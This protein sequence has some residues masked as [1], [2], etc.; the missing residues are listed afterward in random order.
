MTVT[1]K[2]EGFSELEAALDEISKSAGKGVLRRSLKIAATPMVALAKA[3]VP[4]DKGTLRDSIAV[5]S[6]LDKR[7]AGQHRKMFRDD[8]ASVEMFVGPSYNLGKGGRHAHLVEFGTKPHANGGKFAGTM[9]PGTR[10]QPFM[11]P[12]WDKDQKAMLD[13]I[14]KELWVQL[15]KSI[16]R[17]ARKSARG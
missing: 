17:A 12:A 10:P 14:G 2:I 16:A 6:K 3:G 13:R 15:D 7:Q 8:K 11:R 4:V 1:M 5:S 9:H